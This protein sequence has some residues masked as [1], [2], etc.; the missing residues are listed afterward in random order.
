MPQLSRVPARASPSARRDPLRDQMSTRILLMR[1][2]YIV[3]IKE[4]GYHPA[5]ILSPAQSLVGLVGFSIASPPPR[6]QRGL[7]AK[8][9]H[10]RS[11]LAPSVMS[12]PACFRA[13]GEMVTKGKGK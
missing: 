10:Y 2:L 9:V 4:K 1:V 7:S 5:D 11:R 12:T 3:E 6:R 8:I 13:A